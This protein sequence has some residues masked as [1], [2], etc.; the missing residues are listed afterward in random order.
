VRFKFT[1][2][3][4]PYLLRLHQGGNYPL[5]DLNELLELRPADAQHL[6]GLLQEHG[7]FRHPA[8]DRDQLQVLLGRAPKRPSG[9]PP[10]HSQAREELQPTALPFVYELHR[11]GRLFKNMRLV[12]PNKTDRVRV[13]R[14][15][16]Y[17]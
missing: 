5:A 2:D 17:P 14:S 13:L 9:P 6:F 4:L 16:F 10:A 7:T 3:I 12:F 8:I 1:G 15:S 11:D